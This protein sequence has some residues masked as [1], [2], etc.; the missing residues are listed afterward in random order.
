[1]LHL[2]PPHPPPGQSRDGGGEAE[3]EM[4]SIETTVEQKWP[5]LR[6]AKD[7]EKIIFVS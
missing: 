7:F 3:S 5:S 6:E 2:P 4:S 1:M